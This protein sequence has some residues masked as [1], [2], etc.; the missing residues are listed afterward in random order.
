MKDLLK[1]I[2]N[3]VDMTNLKF[4]Y[5]RVGNTSPLLDSLRENSDDSIEWVQ[6]EVD[7]FADYHFPSTYDEYNGAIINLYVN[8][9]EISEIRRDFWENF[10]WR[11]EDRP[12][13]VAII[14]PN[15]SKYGS[16][17]TAEVTEA[18]SLIRMTDRVYRIFEYNDNVAN[19]V[20]NW[21]THI[22]AIVHRTEVEIKTE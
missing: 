3:K 2:F 7:H 12:I 21:L 16:L 14:I 19:D 11:T 13:P 4:H 17:T 8:D 1:Y 18:L 10:V 5:L 6:H 20:S 9:D 15:T 22:S